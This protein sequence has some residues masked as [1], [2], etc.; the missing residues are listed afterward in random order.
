MFAEAGADAVER[1]RV[2]ARVD[3]GQ[4]EADDLQRVPESVV[5]LLRVRVEVEPNEVDV[6]RQEADGE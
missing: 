5:V 4:H 1:D 6:H 3:V 2:G